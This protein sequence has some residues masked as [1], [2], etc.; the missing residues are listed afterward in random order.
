MQHHGLPTRLLDWTEN[1]LT[2]LYFAVEGS[3]SEIGE[4]WC[5]RPDALNNRS[6]YW[7]HSSDASI[8]KYLAAGAFITESKIRR[9]GRDLNIQEPIT[10]NPVAFLPPLEFPRMSAQSSRFTIHP[11][12][13]GGNTI[14]N[15]LEVPREIIRYLV[16]A[17]SKAA[18]SRDLMALGVTAE[19]LFCSLDALATTI[20]IDVYDCDR[21]ESYPEPPVFG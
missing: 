21:G 13:N 18:L 4:V 5:V 11:P 12:P 2:A 3:P 9:L 19:T 17:D 15:L 10:R 6:G 14:E 7:L 8:V 16:P 20:K 1:I